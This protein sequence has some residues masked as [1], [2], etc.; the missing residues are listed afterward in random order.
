[1]Y[2]I[3]LDLSRKLYKLQP[4]PKYDQFPCD[5]GRISSFINNLQQYGGTNSITYFIIQNNKLQNEYTLKLR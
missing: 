4:W 2:M 3:Y 1:M 5:G